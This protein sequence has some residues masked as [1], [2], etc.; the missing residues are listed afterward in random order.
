MKAFLLAGGL[1]T[2]LRPLTDTVPKCLIPI[3][4]EPLISIWLS[5]LEEVGVDELL[6]NLHYLPDAVRRYFS[7]YRG[8][9]KVHMFF[10][11]VLLGSAGTV[12]ANS[13]FI[14][15]EDNF[16]IIYA[17]NLTDTNLGA[18]LDYHVRRR[19]LLTVGAFHAENPTE[20]GIMELDE[21][22]VITGFV[23]KPAEP[24][25]DL[26][27]AGI[28]VATPGIVEFIPDKTPCDF[29]FDVFPSLIGKARGY[30]IDD[31]LID[32]GTLEKYHLAQKLWKE[33]TRIKQKASWELKKN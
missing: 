11:Q 6:L 8:G 33:K 9:L 7:D 24:R 20:C 3:N 16:F 28:Y 23:E 32:I 27:N 13:Q 31:F 30:V 29:G 22:D 18:M 19:P 1:G 5:K 17:D 10:E 26:A 2:R 21:N 15:D 25:S 14:R 12:R 4:G